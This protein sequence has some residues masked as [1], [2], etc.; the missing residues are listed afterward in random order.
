MPFAQIG[1]G[2]TDGADIGGKV[3]NLLPVDAL[4]DDLGLLRGLKGDVL[5]RVEDDGMAENR[6]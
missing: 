6:C 5:R 1:F 2:L 4:D 3:A